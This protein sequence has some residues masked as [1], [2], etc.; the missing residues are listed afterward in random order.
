MWYSFIKTVVG[1]H[2]GIKKPFKGK[3]VHMAKS[4]HK[5]SDYGIDAPPVI[6]NLFIAGTAS[7]ATGVILEYVLATA[8]P[9]WGSIFLGWGLLAGASM[10]LAAALML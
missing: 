8:K 4:T 1:P 9:V 5:N 2:T 7:I 3:E 10:V 6:R